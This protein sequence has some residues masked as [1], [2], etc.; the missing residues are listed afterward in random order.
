MLFFDPNL[1]QT[2]SSYSKSALSSQRPTRSAAHLVADVGW[3][4]QVMNRSHKTNLRQQGKFLLRTLLHFRAST[5]WFRFLRHSYLHDVAHVEPSLL[6]I[7]HRPFFDKNIRANHRVRL[8][9][10]HFEL[11]PKLLGSRQTGDIMS[12]S[13]I[14]L[15]RFEG[16]HAE[17]CSLVMLRDD[18]FKREGG[19]TLALN[20]EGQ[21]LQYL[22]FT[23]VKQEQKTVIK[24]GGIQSSKQCCRETLRKATHALHGIQPRLLLI[25]ALRGIAQQIDCSGIE[26]ISKL[27]HI[28]GAWRYR[29]KKT[30]HAEYD[31]LW[32]LAGGTE[33]NRGNFDLPLAS[34]QKPIESRPSHKRSE[35]RRRG[36]LLESIQ[37]QLRSSQYS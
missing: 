37:Q 28:Y 35:Y 11:L 12:G 14:Q 27:N 34:E 20:F 10:G 21:T 15:C 9:K 33:N 7:I 19:I 36:A 29:L 13:Q 2:A 32:M 30:I 1:T 6:E 5:S 22:T 31:Q 17:Q 8:L 23:M 24:V 4:Y 26:C 3:A 25:E 18:A 16:K